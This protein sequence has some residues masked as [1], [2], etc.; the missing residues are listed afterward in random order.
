MPK[1]IENLLDWLNIDEDRVKEAEL[2]TRH[3]YLLLTKTEEEE[4]CE[5]FREENEDLR[6]M[7][8][9]ETVKMVIEALGREGRVRD[10]PNSEPPEA[11]GKQLR[12]AFK[13][14]KV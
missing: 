14:V 1:V 7:A 11:F 3:L 9:K 13:P 10:F 6:E 8:E 4:A 5:N 2:L 12:T